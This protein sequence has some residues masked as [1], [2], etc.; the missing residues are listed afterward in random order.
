MEAE[1]GHL[2]TQA[3]TIEAVLQ[4]CVH[5]SSHTSRAFARIWTY[6][7]ADNAEL[8]VSA[9]PLHHL[10]GPQAECR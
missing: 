4:G 5:R 8:Q 3:E 9:G 2:I 10:D 1:I 7:E 6:N